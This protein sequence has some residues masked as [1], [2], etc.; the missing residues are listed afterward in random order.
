MYQQ[1]LCTNFNTGIDATIDDLEERD[2]AFGNNKKPEIEPKV[3]K[4]FFILIKG[5]FELLTNA[6]ED[7]TMRILIFASIVSII[8]ETA[9]ADDSHR[10]TAWIEGFAILVAVA[11]CANVTAIND[12]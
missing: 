11:V 5:Y 2:K 10:S 1:G 3:K 7:F 6:L 12:Y 9:T 8:I 4:Y